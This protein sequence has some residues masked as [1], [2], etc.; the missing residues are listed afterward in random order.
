MADE[1]A[2]QLSKALSSLERM[3]YETVKSS[4]L[5]NVVSVA[6]KHSMEVFTERLEMTEKILQ[7]YK[8]VSKICNQ[9]YRR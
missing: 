8:Q 5:S 9:L 6:V 3:E 4:T 7:Y 2:A 1:L